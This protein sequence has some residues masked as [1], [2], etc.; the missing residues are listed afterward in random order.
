MIDM[1]AG[2]RIRH[3]KVNDL[4]RMAEIYAMARR[5]MARNGNATQW[6]SGYPSSELLLADI[7][8]GVSYIIE[9][10]GKAVATFAFIQGD[11]PT[12]AR[13]EGEWPDNAPYGTIHRLASDGSVRGTA[14]ACL[15]FCRS[16]CSNIRIDTHA[17]NLPM[18]RWIEKSGFRFCGIIHVSDGT[19]RRAF[20]LII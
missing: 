11:D 17:D 19:P 8:R 5:F 7:E 9:V 18:L 3:S 12:Y 1:D 16:I 6:G 2:I 20:Q 14:D 15:A 4:P 10:E 13:I